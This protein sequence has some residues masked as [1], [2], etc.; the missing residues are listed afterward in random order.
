MKKLFLLASIS[1]LLSS[2]ALRPIGSQYSF[3]KTDVENIT[4]DNL[5]DGKVL[6]YNGADIL[7]RMDNTARLNI[8]IQGKPLGQLRGGEYVII[9]LNEAEYNVKLHHQ[10]V[11]NMRSEHKLQINDTVKVVRVEPTLTSNKLTIT[12]YLPDRFKRFKYTEVR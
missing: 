8:W 2:C 11:F 1:L 9:Q 10:D 7:H 12:N 3:I 4:L 6:F 5:G